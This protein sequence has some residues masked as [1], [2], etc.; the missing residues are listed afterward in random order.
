MKKWQTKFEPGKDKA[1]HGLAGIGMVGL[2]AVILGLPLG[3]AIVVAVAF[4]F[5]KE[6]WDSMGNG[7][8]DIWDLLCGCVGIAIASVVVYLYLKK[9][10]GGE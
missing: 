7:N 9:V 4:M 2:L 6:V 8:P 1:A 5:G 3:F 10:K